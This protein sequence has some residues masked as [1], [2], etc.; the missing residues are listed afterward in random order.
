M[1]DLLRLV[2]SQSAF[3]CCEGFLKPTIAALVDAV[4]EV[5]VPRQ[6]PEQDLTQP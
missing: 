1:F 4:V 5:M 3:T 2:P 6:A